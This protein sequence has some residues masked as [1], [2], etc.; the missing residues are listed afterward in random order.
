MTHDDAQT[1]ALCELP[2][3]DI[4]DDAGNA[5][6]CQGCRDVFASLETVDALEEE[7]LQNR[8]ESDTEATDQST[9]ADHETT[10]LDVEGMYCASCEAFIEGV[11]EETDGVS[12]AQA[13]YVTETAK[14]DHDPDAVD[15]TDLE[16]AISRLG[17]SAYRKGDPM[18][19]RAADNWAFGRLAAGLLLG[20]VVMMQYVLIVYPTY[21][22]GG[23]F[24]DERTAAFFSEA[25][26]TGGGRYFF[27]VIGVLTTI[28]LGFTGKPILQG[29]YVSLRTREPNM[30]LLVALAASSAYVYSTAAIA[31]GRTDIYY[32]VT[33]AV[34]LVVTVG[35]YYETTL[36]N[37]A[38]EKLTDLTEVQV[39]EATRITDDTTETVP[40]EALSP[41]DRVLV[42]TGERVPIDGTVRRGSASVDESVMTGESLP[43]AKEAGD[44]VV[45]GSV[46]ADGSLTIE[47][48]E[49][50][51][52]SLDRISHLVWDLQSSDRG[53]QGLANKLATV[54]V[55]L[56]L[57][58]ALAVAGTYVLLGAAPTEALLVG[59]T[60]LIVSCPCA[61]GLATPLAM[62][63]GLRD[64]LEANIVIFD[65]TVF[66]RIRN[67]QTV[68]FDKTGTLSTGDMEVI[69]ADVP[70]DALDKAAAI[71]RHS[72]HPVGQAIAALS[73]NAP[74][75]TDG[76]SV[77][78][79]EASEG[80][81]DEFERFDQG[82]GG[83]VDGTNVLVGHP[84]LF[85]ARNWT[86][87]DGIAATVAAERED[88]R[89]P[90]VIGLDGVAV[91]TIV[92]GDELRPGWEET[93]MS[94]HEADMDVIVLTGDDRRATVR[95]EEH[96]GITQVYAGVPPEGKQATIANLSA[97]GP[98]VMVGDGTNDA[99]ALAA[100]DLGIA[101]G[102]GTAM[103]ADAAD[104]AIIDDDLNSVQTTFRLA[105]AAGRRI[106]QNIGWAFLY[107]VVAIP[108]AIIGILNPLFAALA[109]G[110]SSLLVVINSS[111][112]LLS[113]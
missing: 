41:G 45:G 63:A 67:A 55:P 105:R 44:T 94:L 28:I 71:E 48:G 30:D 87:P 17:Y 66:E 53:I 59:L 49:E 39:D 38:L 65:E 16:E 61:L 93:L 37:R 85:D 95:F 69:K 103:A 90:V 108:V 3:T 70:E 43:V 27:I 57:V 10:F 56:V 109:M 68:V 75:A 111:R 47:V 50:V 101:L 106:K 22:E 19:Q 29:A 42:R 15:A 92:L 84:D 58:T 72:S 110:T 31:L 18:R 46:V 107:N 82:V 20:M 81:I 83:V 34:I 88:G 102:S 2:A 51:Q 6:C 40:I 36:K 4:T 97:S 86:V 104:V 1:C 89:I 98:T 80:T 52:S 62:A 64:A 14:I 32:D 24:Y 73:E 33:V 9:P 23:L 12:R 21:F 77:S 76:G 96:P 112:S 35:G 26:A 78:V 13:S 99:P 5:F 113:K 8:L 91:G 74:V 11:A 25:V 79:T 100:A 60:V 7:D 54:F